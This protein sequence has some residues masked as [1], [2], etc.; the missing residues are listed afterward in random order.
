MKSRKT[1]TTTAIALAIGLAL[2]VP[3]VRADARN[4]D[5]RLT[6]NNPLRVSN[7]VVLEPGSYWFRLADVGSQP[8]TMVEVLDDQYDHI[9]NI[10]TENTYRSMPLPNALDSDN[11][12]W[13]DATIQIVQGS[14]GG[15]LHAGDGRMA[16]L[17]QDRST[18]GDDPPIAVVSDLEGENGG[19][20]AVSAAPKR[21]SASGD[22]QRPATRD[23][24]HQILLHREGEGRVRDIGEH[25]D[26][27]LL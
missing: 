11:A 9:T 2:C 25:Q 22:E 12:I 3:A 13:T 5:T 24:R 7:D 14:D 23:I 1:L 19:H 27:H 8:G 10:A 4:Q 21:S 18:E 26:G 16:G 17:D 20:R 6:L 15:E